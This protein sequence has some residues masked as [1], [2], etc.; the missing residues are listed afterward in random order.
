MSL[1]CLRWYVHG[2]GSY[3]GELAYEINF[4][5]KGKI[6]E[7]GL[8]IV[9]E[10]N[11]NNQISYFFYL[12]LYL[13]API[14][15]CTPIANDHEIVK[16]LSFP[17]FDHLEYNFR[18]LRNFKLFIV[19]FFTLQH[20]CDHKEIRKLFHYHIFILDKTTVDFGKTIN[21]I[22]KWAVFLSVVHINHVYLIKLH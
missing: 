7:T 12:I 13:F 18:I 10:S 5:V 16:T 17:L 3:L 6:T 11:A 14:E 2:I 19:I 9:E 21:V 4:I 22:S 15:E 1:F 8:K 20:E